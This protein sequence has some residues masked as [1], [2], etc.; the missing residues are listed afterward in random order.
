MNVV[1]LLHS[2]KSAI[3]SQNHIKYNTRE[4][5]IM[6]VV[7]VVYGLDYW[8]KKNSTIA[9]NQTFHPL[10]FFTKYSVYSEG[11]LRVLAG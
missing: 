11:A 7:C 9:T 3:Q 4:K 10:H 5:F 6:A 1:Y 2:L 8:L